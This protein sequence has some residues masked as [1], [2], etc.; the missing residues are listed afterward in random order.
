MLDQVLTQFE[1]EPDADLNI[2]RPNQDLAGLTARLL[3]ELDTLLRRWKP[4]VALVQGDTTTAL[5][6]ALGAYYRRIPVGH[7]EAG[8]RT[9]QRYHPFPEEMNRQLV[10]A[11]AIHHFAPTQ[12]AAANLRQ[13]GIRPD[14]IIVTGNTGIDALRMT[15]EKLA[16]KGAD[17]LRRRAPELFGIIDEFDDIVLVTSHRRENFGAGLSSICEAL[18][19]LVQAFPRVCVIYPVHPNPNVS[20]VTRQLLGGQ[21]RIHLV[22]PLDYE[23]F[24][25]LMRSCRLILTD[26]GGI[27][28]EAPSLDKPVLVL[29]ETSER[30]EV[31]EAGAALV[32]GTSRVRIVEAAARLLSDPVAYEKMTRRTN[33]YGDGHAATRI[34]AHLLGKRIEDVELPTSSPSG[35]DDP[36]V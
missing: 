29:R 3:E 32:V 12:W 26:S 9:R 19:D 27:Q 31:V 20:G 1:I 15:L 13:E 16:H 8:L 4:D 11:L 22:A 24:C 36:I 34:V 28:E 23:L 35:P 33:P 17:E 25:F 2:M 6:G 21:E 10:D 18:K 14:G 5:A 30:P 7:V